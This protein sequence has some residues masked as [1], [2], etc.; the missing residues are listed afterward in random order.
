MNIRPV[1]VSTVLA[2]AV[3]GC[4]A[5]G[6]DR[7]VVVSAAS[8]LADAFAD[9]EESFEETHPGVDVVLN[10]G[11]SSGLREQILAGAPVDVYASADIANMEAVSAAGLVAESA[12]F[13]RNRLQIAVPPGNPGGV[14]GLADLARPEL[15][16]GLCDPAVPCGALARRLFDLAGLEP[17]VDTSEPNVR[18]LLTKIEEGEVDVGLVYVTDVQAAEGRVEGIDVGVEVTTDYSI[19]V[20]SGAPPAAEAFV[21]TVLSDEGRAVL[22][23]FGFDLP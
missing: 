2:L 6:Q 8:S 1:F 20:L 11:A 21:E 3:A 10:L 17:A 5:G 14:S 23:R 18:S 7:Q 12:V 13:A 4:V 19:A 15:V 16:V 9:I 22:T